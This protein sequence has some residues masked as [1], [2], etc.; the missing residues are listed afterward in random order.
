VTNFA[1]FERTHRIDAE[2]LLRNLRRQGTPDR[3][4]FMEL[5]YDEEIALAL[6]ERFGVTSTLDKSAADHAWRRQIA[7]QRFLGYDTVRTK[8]FSLDTGQRLAIDDTVSGAQKRVSRHWL[9]EHCGPIGSWEDFERYP[10]PDPGR[11]PWDTRELEF[12]ERNLPDDMAVVVHG[13]HFCEYLCWLTGYERLCY[14]LHDDRPLVQAV[15]DKVLA[16]EEAACKVA[17]QFSR[18]K[19]FWGSD[20]MGF[21]TGL[22]FSP[23]DM[24]HFVLGGHRALARIVHQAGG[25]YLLH[26]CGRRADIIE[27]LIEDVRI[28]ALHSWEDAIEPVTEAKRAYGARLSLLGGI[29]MDL[30]TRG[31][32]EAVRARV[33]EV[34]AVCQPGGGYC[35]G[36][37]N[38]VANYIPLRNY[39]AMLDEGRRW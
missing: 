36:S 33:R 5:F 1:S 12:Y 6:E 29:D 24:R 32:E 4:F 31:T 11:H 37:G 28:D 27:D 17:M 16:L 26:A 3:V 15:A 39:L 10:W 22:M 35:L 23:E 20:D 8:L 25:L 18:V 34:L 13:G 30:L 38:S 9:N 19:L 14:L 2:G 7:L 21:R